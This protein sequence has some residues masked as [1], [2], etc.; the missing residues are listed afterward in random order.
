VLY[1]S[2]C[3]IFGAPHKHNRTKRRANRA[4]RRKITKKRHCVDWFFR[5]TPSGVAHCCSDRSLTHGKRRKIWAG[6]K[7]Q[8]KKKK[9]SVFRNSSRRPYVVGRQDDAARRRCA[10]SNCVSTHAPWL[11]RCAV[12]LPRDTSGKRCRS[13]DAPTTEIGARA[14]VRRLANSVRPTNHMLV[15]RID[16]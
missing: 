12:W 7:N 1:I 2:V 4:A 14:C 16:R 10:P 9:R 8:K 15:A 5:H 11:C 13:A 3:T 6:H